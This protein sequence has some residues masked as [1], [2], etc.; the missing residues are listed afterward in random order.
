[1]SQHKVKASKKAKQDAKLDEALMESFP[2]SDPVALSQPAP[3]EPEPESDALRP[4]DKKAADKARSR[5]SAH[6]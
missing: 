4:R 6:R 2:G 1:M 3:A 5:R